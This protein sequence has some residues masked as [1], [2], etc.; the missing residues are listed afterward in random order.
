M[1]V[2]GLSIKR[3]VDSDILH[4]LFSQYGK[5]YCL[6]SLPCTYVPRLSKTAAPLHPV[7]APSPPSASRIPKVLSVTIMTEPA[8]GANNG[9]NAH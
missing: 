6:P 2:N 3:V 7:Q 5:V 1:H 4:K 8:S 9:C